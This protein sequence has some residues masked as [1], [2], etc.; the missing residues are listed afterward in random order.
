MN[1]LQQRRSARALQGQQPEFQIPELDHFHLKSISGDE[2]TYLVE[3]FEEV[4]EQTSNVLHEMYHHLNNGDYEA[5]AHVTQEYQSAVDIL[6]EP[7]FTQLL[8]RIER[9]SRTSQ[10]AKNLLPLLKE[11]TT[12]CECMKR[13]LNYRLMTLKKSG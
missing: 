4:M 9:E 2:K 7:R 12:I 11:L 6:G 8:S 3:T 10:N 1:K 5:L 13:E